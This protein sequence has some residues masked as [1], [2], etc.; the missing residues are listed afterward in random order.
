MA[1]AFQ[2]SAFQN[3]AFQVAQM[4][5]E[6]SIGAPLVRQ[7]KDNLDLETILLAWWMLENE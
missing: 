7:K 5:Q 3:N 2:S 4:Q 6:N 1:T